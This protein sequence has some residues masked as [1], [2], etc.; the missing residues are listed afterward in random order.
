MS[1]LKM[2]LRKLFIKP[3][4]KPERKARTEAEAHG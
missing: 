3:H 1:E 2:P 4:K